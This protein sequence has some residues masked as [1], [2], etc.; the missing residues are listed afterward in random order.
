MLD[1]ANRTH[2]WPDATTEAAVLLDLPQQGVGSEKKSM[3]LLHSGV[4]LGHAVE[5]NVNSSTNGHSG[6]QDTPVT[7]QII[8]TIK[9]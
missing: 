8:T 3:Q 4:S 9:T 1:H 6:H 7:Q 5:N 2:H